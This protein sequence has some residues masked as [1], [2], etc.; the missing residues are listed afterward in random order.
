MSEAAKT[1]WFISPEGNAGYGWP[2]HAKQGPV[3]VCP[4]KAYG[5]PDAELIVRAVNAFEP[6]VDALEMVRDADEDCKRDGLTTMPPIPRAKIEAAL[7][8]ARG[9]Q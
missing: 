9:E 7:A 6:L 1:P 8:K 3:E 5:L 2:I 4:A